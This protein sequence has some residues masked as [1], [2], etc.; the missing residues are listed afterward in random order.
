MPRD[1]TNIGQQ[2][3]RF[4]HTLVPP[5]DSGIDPINPNFGR[6]VSEFV[7]TLIPPDTPDTPP[8]TGDSIG[9]QVS[10]FVHV[11]IAPEDDPGVENPTTIGPQVSRFVHTLVTPDTGDIRGETVASDWLL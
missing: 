4:V 2:V 3:S 5:D 7:H 11:L 6:Q 9:R 10:A 1:P 8:D